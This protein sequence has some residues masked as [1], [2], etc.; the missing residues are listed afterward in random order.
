[1][2]SWEIERLFQ[3]DIREKRKTGSGSFHRRGKGVKHGLSGAL[4]TPYHYMKTKE[5]NKLNG[6]VETFNMYETIISWNE[7]QLKDNET[8]KFM[9]TRWRELYPNQKIM[10]ELGEGM[11][12]KF[13]SQS[14]ADLV[15]SLGCP[16]KQKG[17]S[18]PRKASEPKRAY[19]PRKAKTNTVAISSAPT[20]IEEPEQA[21]K[22]IT[23]GLSLEY[24]GEYNSEQLNKIFTK[25]QLLTDGE[26]SKFV[27]S[28][29]IQ[30]RI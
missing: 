23:N 28:V 9:L 20:M 4:K 25:L 14:F 5:K 6:E 15:N 10:D 19:S 7:F 1:M 30:E 11:D 3:D 22:L 29:T 27:L 8:K 12:R 16:P 18:V 21:V 2:K 13:N 26:E 17:G 24:N